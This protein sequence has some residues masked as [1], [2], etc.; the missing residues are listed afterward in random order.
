MYSIRC[1]CG[2]IVCQVD[3]MPYL[4]KVEEGP[5][6]PQ[7]P[8]VVI[9]CRHCRRYAVMRIPTITSINFAS[10]VAP[11]RADQVFTPNG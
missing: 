9:L 8:S 6:T 2:K 4:P 10:S 5:Q 3:S 7:S 1:L 11:P